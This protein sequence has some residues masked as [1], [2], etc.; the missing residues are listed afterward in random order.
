MR[1][2][3]GGK[4]ILEYWKMCDW[5]DTAWRGRT[6]DSRLI[7]PYKTCIACC[8]Q[9]NWGVALPAYCSSHG[10]R[11]CKYVEDLS[12]SPNNARNYSGREAE[13]S[14]DPLIGTHGKER[15]WAGGRWRRHVLSGGKYWP[16]SPTMGGGGSLP[17]HP[18][19]FPPSR[20]QYAINTGR[21]DNQS[22]HC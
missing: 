19:R 22:K 17:S 11:K 8:I 12:D 10:K 2:T 4:W 7:I 9:Q 21:P 20:R 16:P 13:R 1:H 14:S 18:S 5:L 15:P 3:N 6:N